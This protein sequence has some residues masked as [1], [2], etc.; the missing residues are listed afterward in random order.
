MK[1]LESVS[2]KK[3][4]MVEVADVTATGTRGFPFLFELEGFLSLM[5]STA[6]STRS[7]GQK[8]VNKGRLLPLVWDT[9]SNHWWPWQWRI[10]DYWRGEKSRLDYLKVSGK[11]KIWPGRDAG[12]KVW[13]SPNVTRI[14]PQILLLLLLELALLRYFSLKLSGT[15][16]G[17]WYCFFHSKY[18]ECYHVISSA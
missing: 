17:C 9:H 13:E 12:G 6:N 8:A 10:N 14:Y 15:N 4:H 18:N 2:V 11:L 7:I 5:G 16:I 3:L 1:P